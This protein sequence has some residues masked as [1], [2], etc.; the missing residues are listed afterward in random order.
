[1]LMPTFFSNIYK[2][3]SFNGFPNVFRSQKNLL[4]SQKC[5]N[6]GEDWANVIK[7][8][9]SGF[10]YYYF[11]FVV[12]LAF[13]KHCWGRSY[14]LSSTKHYV[15]AALYTIHIIITYLYVRSFHL[16]PKLKSLTPTEFTKTY[17]EQN[18]PNLHPLWIS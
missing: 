14:I 9:I 5:V 7:Q 4:D 1:M 15:Y 13:S 3:Q 2:N 17:R 18:P 10:F 12:R 16:N 11:L 6:F 8:V